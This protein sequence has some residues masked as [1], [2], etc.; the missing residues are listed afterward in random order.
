MR[1]SF[2]LLVMMFF[3][4]VLPADVIMNLSM[5][6]QRY[7]IYEPVIANL[8]LRNTSGQGLIFGHEAEFKGFLEIGLFD[9]HNRPLKG[10]G[11]KI[12]LKGLILRPGADQQIRVNIGKWLDMRR[13]G[14]YKLKVYISHPMLKNEYE[15]NFCTFDITG[16]QIFWQR[17]FGIPNLQGAQLGEDL[18]MRSYIIKTMGN[19]SDIH[20]YLFIEDDAKVYAVKY[21]G[22]L[23]GRERPS[24]EIDSLNQLHI[25]LPISSKKFCYTVFDWHGNI[26]KQKY[27]RI[28]KTIPVL[29]RQSSNGE[30][31]VIGGEMIISDESSRSEKL[32]PGLPADAIPAQTAS[33]DR[34][35][36]TPQQPNSL[37]TNK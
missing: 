12:S 31:S 13:A 35:S 28:G 34:Q 3:S 24:C 9:M 30:V 32:L 16:G 19:N 37:Q 29:Y 10:S 7:M 5:P 1:I 17:K 27:Y 36:A 33:P 14:F 25:L 23:L 21:L 22:T 2:V 6:R 26:E 11:T 18:K 8:A 4:A 15:S 20:L